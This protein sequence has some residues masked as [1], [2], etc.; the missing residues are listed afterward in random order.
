M[1]ILVCTVAYLSLSV[2][3]VWALSRVF[4]AP[5]APAAP[6]DRGP[7]GPIRH[8]FWA[9]PCHCRLYCRTD[10][11]LDVEHLEFSH[12]L[13]CPIAESLIAGGATS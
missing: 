2:V 5:A 4:S 6:M 9:R 7:A 3:T 1:T 12:V 8:P 10:D 13:E 11:L